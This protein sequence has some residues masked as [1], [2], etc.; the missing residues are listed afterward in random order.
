MR[1]FAGL[2]VFLFFV[3]LLGCSVKNPPGWPEGKATG[4][5]ISASR[6]V[7]YSL[8][9]RRYDLADG[10]EIRVDL[11]N[12]AIASGWG[13]AAAEVQFTTTYVDDPDPGLDCVTEPTGPGVPETRFSCWSR[14]D[15][16]ALRFWLAPGVGCHLRE[17]IQTTTRSECWQGEAMVQGKRILLRRGH[18]R[19]LGWPVGNISWVDE[20]EQ[21]LLVADIVREQQFHLYAGPIAPAPEMRRALVLLTVALAWYEHATSPS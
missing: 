19:R 13:K 1:Y 2:P 6:G 21:A 16:E 9:P 17:A 15:P 10:Q 18:L 3:A 12:Y 8:A 5:V 7:M 14:A 4:E 20:H 11:A